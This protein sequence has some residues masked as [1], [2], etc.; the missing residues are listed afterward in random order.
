MLHALLDDFIDRMK[1]ATADRFL[2]QLLGFG[3]K[4]QLDRHANPLALIVARE[5]SK[6]WDLSHAQTTPA[7]PADCCLSLL[8]GISRRRDGCGS[9]D[10][11][12]YRRGVHSRKLHQ[13]R[14]QNPDA[15]RRE[16]VHLRL[17]PQR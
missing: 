10:L 1:V 4:L 13:V 7:P 5:Q 11:D 16:A 17:H 3:S 8:S 2:N 9:D 14:I 12:E 15:R 6:M